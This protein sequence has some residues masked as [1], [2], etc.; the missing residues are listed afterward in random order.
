MLANFHDLDQLGR[1]G[2]QIDHIAS[3]FRCL[4]TGV[5]RDRYIRLSQGR[6]II[7]SIAGH[8][9]QPAFGLVFA[10]QRQL[11]FRR[12]FGQ[13]IIHARLG[14]DGSRCQVIVSSN[15]YRFDAHAT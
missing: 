12:G 10:D 5:H 6:R 3:F 15:H 4:G 1:V 9:H 7:G 11:R 8:G 13:K 14:G 2:V